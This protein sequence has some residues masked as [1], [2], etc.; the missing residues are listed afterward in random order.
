MMRG[1][2]ILLPVFKLTR[3]MY[4]VGVIV[5]MVMHHVP[6]FVGTVPRGSTARP[7][8]PRF[9]YLLTALPHVVLFLLFLDR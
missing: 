4:R 9:S 6:D 1:C 7:F 8:H 2:N 5:V 3:H